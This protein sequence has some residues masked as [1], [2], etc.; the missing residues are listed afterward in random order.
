MGGSPH[1]PARGSPQ[2]EDI[3]DA[4]T[5]EVARLRPASQGQL[6]GLRRLGLGPGG[7][8]LVGLHLLK[9]VIHIEPDPAGD[10]SV[11]P[12]LPCRWPCHH[13]V[14]EHRSQRPRGLGSPCV[15]AVEGD[16]M[17]GTVSKAVASFHLRPQQPERHAALLQ[18]HL[19]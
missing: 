18:G 11:S 9:L 5:E 6:S 19:A 13:P 17:G 16:I 2:H 8:A 14:P 7:R 15:I 4:A 3:A 12:T 10:S 1:S